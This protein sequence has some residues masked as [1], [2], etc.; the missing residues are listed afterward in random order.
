MTTQPWR[1]GS[2]AAHWTWTLEP[3]EKW[4][5]SMHFWNTLKG[6]GS[7]GCGGGGLSSTGREASRWSAL[8][9][10]LLD[11]LLTHFLT[12]LLT[13]LITCLLTNWATLVLTYLLTHS[14]DCLLTCLLPCLL[15]DWAPGAAARLGRCCCCCCPVV[16]T[17][18]KYAVGAGA[19]LRPQHQGCHCSDAA[20][21]AAPQLLL[22][23]RAAAGSSPPFAA[24]AEWPPHSALD[25]VLLL[26]PGPR[27]TRCAVAAAASDAATDPPRV[28]KK[29][30]KP[31]E[32]FSHTVPLQLLMLPPDAAA[33]PAAPGACCGGDTVPHQSCIAIS[34][35]AP[36]AAL[37]DPADSPRTA[38]PA[39]Y[40]PA[41]A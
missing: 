6:G 39:A 33:C 12:Y 2:L 40:A 1:S 14:L 27:G 18:L 23:P 17:S 3:S 36:R 7:S 24:A 26:L 11:Y 29:L 4:I 25:Y 20:D 10:Y 5:V 34:T 21:P 19:R 35:A 15:T 28:R 41:S 13:Y 8:I 9:A 16:S 38:I 37:S 22:L 32:T 30:P 31:C